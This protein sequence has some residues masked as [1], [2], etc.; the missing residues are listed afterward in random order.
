[1]PFNSLKHPCLLSLSPYFLNE[2]GSRRSD[3]SS[4]IMDVTSP[5]LNTNAPLS[6]VSSHS[7]SLSLSLSLARARALL[8]LFLVRSAPFVSCSMQVSLVLLVSSSALVLLQGCCTAARGWTVLK[9]DA[10]EVLPEYRERSPHET[11]TH[12]AN[13]SSNTGNRAK[14]G[15][16]SASTVSYSKYDTGGSIYLSVCLSVSVCLSGWLSV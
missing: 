15:G 13:G 16:R 8:V 11:A 5:L 4:L 12:A 10:T 2:S 6:P 3:H 7:L 9:N 14:S 1:M